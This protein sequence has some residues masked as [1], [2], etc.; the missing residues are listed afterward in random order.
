MFDY[1]WLCHR[2]AQEA[3]RLPGVV[4]I[5]KTLAPVLP[6]KAVLGFSESVITFS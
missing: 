4:N 5:S 6:R 2:A 3:G 1:S